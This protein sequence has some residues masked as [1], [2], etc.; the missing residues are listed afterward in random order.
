MLE[1]SETEENEECFIDIGL[2]DSFDETSC[3]QYDSDED[4]NVC[5]CTDGNIESIADIESISFP[6]VRNIDPEHHLKNP[7]YPSVCELC[8]NDN[9]CMP[10]HYM[11]KHRNH[12]MLVARPSPSMAERLRLKNDEFK[13]SD[14]KI[15]DGLCYFCEEKLQMSRS[16]WVPHILMHTGEILYVCN[17]SD[18]SIVGFLC[19]ECNFL[20]LEQ[21]RV[22]DHL[23]NDH[24]FEC[25]T[26]KCHY[27]KV[28]LVPCVEHK[29][30]QTGKLLEHVQTLISIV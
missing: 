13:M 8:G 21:K 30:T 12:E 11:Q 23:E 28:T 7:T 27:E 24:G 26:E 9:L 17:S 19:N 29:T 20:Q 2:I 18:R 5:F 3:T 4:E 10:N 15:I 22:I 6:Y 14:G 1:T 25:P 16:K